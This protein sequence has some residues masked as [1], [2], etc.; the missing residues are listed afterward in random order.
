MPMSSS[1]IRM[2]SMD[3]ERAPSASHNGQLD[4]ERRALAELALDGGDAIVGAHDVIDHRQPEAGA[5]RLQ[6]RIGAGQA[7]KLLE[8]AAVLGLGNARTVVADRE[9]DVR[10]AARAAHGDGL[11]RPGVL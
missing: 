1:T 6:R 10:A 2:V 3:A 9:G 5:L 7:V 8:D 11:L 4:G